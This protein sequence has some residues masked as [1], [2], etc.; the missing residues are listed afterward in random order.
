MAQL[1]SML[2]A[3]AVVTQDTLAQVL[4]HLDAAA[5]TLQLEAMAT[6][7]VARIEQL[8]MS[9]RWRRLLGRPIAPGR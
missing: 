5:R 7:V 8:V 6:V 2:R 1:R 9:R 3:I 4:D